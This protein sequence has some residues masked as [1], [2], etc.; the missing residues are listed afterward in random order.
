MKT[1]YKVTNKET[2]NE[3][4]VDVEISGSNHD[5]EVEI[6][7]TQSGIVSWEKVHG[8]KLKGN[9]ISTTG[10]HG[11]SDYEKEYGFILV[12]E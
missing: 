6:E 7:L 2:F 9:R 11:A 8:S 4:V 5:M 10:E 3:N 1:T 12:S